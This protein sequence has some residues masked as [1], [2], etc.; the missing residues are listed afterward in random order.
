[1][2]FITQSDD[3]KQ[4][5]AMRMNPN[6]KYLIVCEQRKRDANSCF[7]SI[8]DLKTA[9]TPKLYKPEINITEMAKEIGASAQPNLASKQEANN[10]FGTSSKENAASFSA[11]M[12]TMYSNGPMKGHGEPKP[13]IITHFSFSP[14]GVGKYI[15][16]VMCNETD[17]KVI[18]FDWQ[19]GHQGKVEAAMEFP[20]QVIDRVSFN[21]G[22]ENVICTSGPNHWKVWRIHEGILK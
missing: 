7:I 5:T 16:M 8:Y 9:E 11:A 18:V 2:N 12:N 17:S 10:N 15:V 19:N 13:M 20:K 22:D 1:M 3:V 6:Q 4:I 21:P 14:S